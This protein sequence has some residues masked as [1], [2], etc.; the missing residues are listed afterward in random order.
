VCW[1]LYHFLKCSAYFHFDIGSNILIS[2]VCSNQV[3]TIL[4]YTCG[5]WMTC[6]KPDQMVWFL[7]LV[8]LGECTTFMWRGVLKSHRRR[9]KQVRPPLHRGQRKYPPLLNREHEITLATVEISAPPLIGEKSIPPLNRGFQH[10]PH[11]INYVHSLSDTQKCR[12][13]LSK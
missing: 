2:Y 4:T 1:R 5:T 6:E 10:T 12:P 9:S 3:L 8:E 11:H 7:I 13:V